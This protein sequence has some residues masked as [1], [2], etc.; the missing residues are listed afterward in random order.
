M[1]I[2]IRIVLADDHEIFRDGF[3]VMLKKQ[4][5][6]ELIGEAENGEELIQITRQTNPDVIITD[7]KMPR[8]DG[9]EATRRL[10]Q[11]FPHIGIIALSMFDEENLIIDM[12]EAGAKGYLLK[13]THKDDI[14]NAIQAVYRDQTYYCTHTSSKLAQ[15]I[16]RSTFNPHKKA[17]KPEFTEREL[18]IIK[19]ICQ[20]LSNKEIAS[21]LHLSVRTIEGYREK[22]QE[23]I[24]ARNAAGIVVYAIRN[25][26]YKV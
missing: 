2:P 3:R 15:M 20:E 8:L 9:I 13:N 14:L 21:Q 6:V 25:H 7:I 16:A 26:I 24:Q 4:P 11:E 10:C 17:A 23:K 1:N 19:L 12:L 18:E 5:S 22:I